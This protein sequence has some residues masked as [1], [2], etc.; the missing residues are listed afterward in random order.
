MYG[1]FSSTLMQTIY[2]CGYQK[3]KNKHLTLSFLYD[4]LMTVMAPVNAS[5]RN[6][7]TANYLDTIRANMQNF[8]NANGSCMIYNTFECQDKKKRIYFLKNDSKCH[9]IIC[10]PIP[11]LDT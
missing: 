4:S 7:L 5:K 2:M 6:S 3:E 10:A 1:L 9:L 11:H 8:T